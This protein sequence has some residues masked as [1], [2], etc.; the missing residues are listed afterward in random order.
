M[1][2][3]LHKFLCALVPAALLVGCAAS[4]T[5]VARKGNL[6]TVNAKLGE[7]ALDQEI[8]SALVSA[9]TN[10]HIDVVNALLESRT[11]NGDS[12]EAVDAKEGGAA[13]NRALI[14]ALNSASANGHDDVVNALLEVLK[15]G[16]NVGYRVDLCTPLRL[17]LGNGQLSVV[18]ILLAHQDERLC[19]V[20]GAGIE[21]DSIVHYLLEA[22]A[23]PNE[24]M[25]SAH[26]PVLLAA[27]RNGYTNV[28]KMLLDKGASVNAQMSAWIKVKVENGEHKGYDKAESVPGNT[29]LTLAV[30]HRHLDI[31]RI[32]LDHGADENQIVTWQDDTF[33]L[34]GP[35]EPYP[36]YSV[37]DRRLYTRMSG[38]AIDIA[39]V[40]G[41]PWPPPSK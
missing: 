38:S 17:A 4:L 15:P 32:L 35:Y 13:R 30:R 19:G 33:F 9:S 20:V 24:Y 10:G 6:E 29:A 37:P 39:Q 41:L 2:R 18:K 8:L 22:G 21:Y 31:A 25:E 27:S 16:P 7:G 26:M 12:L 40:L 3:F 11:L 5:D 14:S 36:C 23:D 1:R 28:V 34:C